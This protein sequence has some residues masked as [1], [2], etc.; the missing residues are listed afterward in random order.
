MV[1]IT[2]KN[3][4]WWGGWGWGWTW[5][6]ITWTLS[7]QTDLQTALN[8][9]LSI[10]ASAWGDLTGTYPNPT[11]TTT[12]VT[13]GSYTSANITVDSKWRITAATNGSSGWITSLNWLTW[14]TQT[15]AV[16]TAGTDFAITSTGT[17]HT[18]DIPTASATNR[19]LLS[20]TDWS[21]FNSKFTLP[22]LSNQSV[23]FSNGTTITQDNTHFKYDGT[24]LIVGGTVN[25]SKR[26]LI[27]RTS[28]DA[29]QWAVQTISNIN[30]YTNGI[31]MVYSGVGSSAIW[32]PAASSMAFGADTSSG[33]TEL[34]R[35]TSTGLVIGTT[36]A[37]ARLHTRGA[38]ATSATF[39]FLA[40]NS[41]WTQ[42]F[43]VR[44]DGAVLIGTDPLNITSQSNTTLFTNTG[45]Y[46][47][48]SSGYGDWMSFGAVIN[49][50]TFFGAFT[51]GHPT[52]GNRV[53]AHFS[54]WASQ[55][56]P[57]TN[58]TDSYQIYAADVNGVGGTTAMH[59]RT[60]NWQVIKHYQETTAVASAT[61]VSPGAWNVIKTDDTFDWY[62]LAQIV[63]WLRLKWHFA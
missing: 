33:W 63:R 25:A 34:M 24:H 19:W 47:F 41:A 22:S 26:L 30:Q 53:I 57:T 17:A 50:M 4:G 6:S 52:S 59:T 20:S 1:L 36:T 9:K 10:G 55:S 62:T 3:W 58:V 37:S 35:L 46:R 12:A 40:Q 28:S 31:Q 54:W 15:F 2:K 23:L 21:A 14:S 32:T 48:T 49:G 18:F 11:L 7:N 5:W 13:P 42:H 56:A 43:A 45:N 39:S 38:G 61:I 60:E 27:G 51:W 44:N 16:G 29:F 8:L